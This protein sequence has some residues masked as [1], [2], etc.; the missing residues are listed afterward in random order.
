MKSWCLDRLRRRVECHSSLKSSSSSEVHESD[1]YVSMRRAS[2]AFLERERSMMG[3]GEQQL[4]SST[5]EWRFARSARS[6]RRRQGGERWTSPTTRR[7][8]RPYKTAPLHD[9]SAR[10]LYI[11]TALV[12]QGDCLPLSFRCLL[13]RFQHV[14]G[15]FKHNVRQ[16][17][18]ICS[19]RVSRTC[20]AILRAQISMLR[21]SLQTC[22][23]LD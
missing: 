20:C 9:S 8:M 4:G 13:S 14:A 17:H 5:G 18:L 10:M 3:G 22:R 19:R 1:A 15:V 23:S 7:T 11:S 16:R 12:F 21:Y 2:S 6:R